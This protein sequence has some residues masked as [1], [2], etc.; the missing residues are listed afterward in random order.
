MRGDQLQT[1]P[2]LGK[3]ETRRTH[4]VQQKLQKGV[5][6]RDLRQTRCEWSEKRSQL[7]VNE[8]GM[9]NAPKQ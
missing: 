9:Q 3:G 5:V 1:R 2:Q 8:D 4:C 6:M 7:Q